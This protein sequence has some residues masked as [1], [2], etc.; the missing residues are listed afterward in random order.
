MAYQ[1]QSV[2]MRNKKTH[3]IDKTSQTCAAIKQKYDAVQ[4]VWWG[5]VNLR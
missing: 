4:M 1:F 3:K 5:D 2:L